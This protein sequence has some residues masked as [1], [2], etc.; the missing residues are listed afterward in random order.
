MSPE[1]LILYAQKAREMAYAPYSGFRVGAALLT[2]Q[3]NVYTGC[4]VENSS[5][6]LTVCAERVAIFNA[7]CAGERQ[8][9]ALAICAGTKSFCSPC[10]ACRQVL[11]EFGRDTEVY[12]SNDKGEYKLMTAAELMPAAFELNIEKLSE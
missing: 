11:L 3:G 10:G 1:K 6:G 7:V 4:N 12:M 9:K 8:F 5:Y 2:E